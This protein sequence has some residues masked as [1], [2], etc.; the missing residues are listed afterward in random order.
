MY[1]YKNIDEFIKEA[2][3]SQI[4]EDF[5]NESIQKN[6]LSLIHKSNTEDEF[7]QLLDTT[8]LFDIYSAEAFK[9]MYIKDSI[10]NLHMSKE[11]AYKNFN[12]NNPKFFVNV[13]LQSGTIKSIIQTLLKSKEFKKSYNTVL[14]QFID[15][16]T[17]S[18]TELNIQ[19]T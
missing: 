2:G 18:L 9:D 13:I 10:D 1:N 15:D 11:K 3:Y 6:L 16:V 8:N 14:A 19:K 7:I 5:F 17:N 12:M 4:I